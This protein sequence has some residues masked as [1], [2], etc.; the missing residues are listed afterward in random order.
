MKKTILSV[1]AGLT[2]VGMANAA[3]M[4]IYYSP[5]CPHC[6]HA[7]DFIENELIYEYNDLKVTLIN[8]FE[9]RDEFISTIK[10]CNYNS[11]GVPVMVI[12]EKCFQGYAD[13][14]Q[15]DIRSAIEIDLTDAQK[16]SAADN[17]ASFDKDKKS[18]VASHANR[19]D[20]IKEVSIKKKLISDSDTDTTNITLII[21][22]VLLVGALGI[23]FFKKQK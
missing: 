5:T 23:I 12:G 20:S 4:T 7:R 19:K 6:H 15:D 17:K 3:D 2:F 16:Q 10:K 13:S 1:L 8:A 18:F 11:G 14:M 9:N 21:L 22:M